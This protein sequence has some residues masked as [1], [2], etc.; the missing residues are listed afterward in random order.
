LFDIDEAMKVLEA[1]LA[2]QAALNPVEPVE[3]T[4]TSYEEPDVTAT[5]P[6]T[7]VEEIE[8]LNAVVSNDALNSLPEEPLVNEG[9]FLTDAVPALVAPQNANAVRPMV[10]LFSCRFS[11]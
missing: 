5:I 3:P 10:R 4:Q 8:N 6:S 2:V 9:R 1:Q 7:L 11:S